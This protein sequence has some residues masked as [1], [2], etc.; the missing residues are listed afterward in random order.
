MK[1]HHS[2]IIIA[3][4]F[5]LLV[6]WV[7]ADFF[8]TNRFEEVWFSAYSIGKDDGYAAGRSDVTA[9]DMSFKELEYTCMFLYDHK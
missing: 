3:F 4:I 6:S 9:E 8:N 2:K 5:G 1:P 7:A